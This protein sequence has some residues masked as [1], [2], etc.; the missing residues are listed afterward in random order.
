MDLV[1]RINAFLINNLSNYCKAVRVGDKTVGMQKYQIYSNGKE[2]RDKK[3]DS[4]LF[5]EPAKSVTAIFWEEESFRLLPSGW[6]SS[7]P[8]VIQAKRPVLLPKHFFE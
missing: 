4:L 1:S 7:V 3:R 6:P 5:L 8:V 2:E